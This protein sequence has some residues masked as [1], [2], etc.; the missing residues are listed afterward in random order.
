MRIST[1]LALIYLFELVLTSSTIGQELIMN[2]NTKKYYSENVVNMRSMSKDSL[3]E[4]SLKWLYKEYPK[5]GKKETYINSEGKDKILTH[6]FFDPD[7]NN[8]WGYGSS[9]RVGFILTIEFKEERF[10]YNYT[11]FY[12]YSIGD[13]KLLFESNRFQQYDLIMRDRM[14]E[15]TDKYLKKSIAELVAYL[16][17]Y[18]V[19]SD[20]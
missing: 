5:T 8:F 15:E 3:F 4:R 19:N 17:N 7:P 10:K 1:V 6:Q 11:D 18:K 13:G 20:W 14:L 2:D 9:L 12:F 16:Q